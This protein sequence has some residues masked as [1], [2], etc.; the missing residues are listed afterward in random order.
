M[1]T[2]FDTIKMNGEDCVLTR[3]QDIIEQRQTEAAP[4][5][6]QIAEKCMLAESLAKEKELNELK[7][8]FITTVSHEFRTPLAII[9][10]SSQL[11]KNYRERMSIQ[12]QLEHLETIEVQVR[13]LTDM[14]DWVLTTSE[15]HNR[16][17]VFNPERLHMESICQTI[18]D[19]FRPIAPT[20]DIKFTIKGNCEEVAIDP[21]L[22]R[23]VLYNLLSNA[24]QY[25]TECGL[26]RL[27]VACNQDEA[28]I[29]VM[30]EGIGIPEADLQHLFDVFHR[31]ANVG[32][33]QGAGLGLAIVKLAVEAHHGSIS[34][35]STVNKGMTFIVTLPLVLPK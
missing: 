25:S 33:I 16:E 2:S 4:S 15:S 32:S 14:I 13:H 17:T 3:S 24:I 28:I 18:V 1:L 27:E 12:R 34:V 30:D 29:R 10:V 31:A 8:R 35:E 9:L 7:S 22:M 19:E 20:H 23:Q 21:K 26:V 6:T 5:H 11:L